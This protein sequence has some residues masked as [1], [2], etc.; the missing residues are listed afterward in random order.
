M[1]PLTCEALGRFD[2][3]VLLVTG[4]RSVPIFQVITLELER[5]LNGEAHVMVPEADH[6]LH[7]AN[8]DFYTEAVQKFLEGAGS[9]S[10]RQSRQ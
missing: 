1:V 3:P 2:R 10:S 9:A 5:G 6:G 7:V 8:P 4:E